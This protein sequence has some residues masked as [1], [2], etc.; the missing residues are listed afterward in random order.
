MTR[1][2]NAQ[3][4]KPALHP[5]IDEV[6]Y[7][8]TKTGKD[9]TR[10]TL[11][12][13]E[14]AK[15]NKVNRPRNL[16]TEFSEW[17]QRHGG[18][19]SRLLDLQHE[20]SSLEEALV[21]DMANEAASSDLTNKN[22][23]FQKLSKK[24]VPYAKQVEKHS[25]EWKQAQWEYEDFLYFQNVVSRFNRGESGFN[26]EE[27][28]T[29]D[30]AEWTRARLHQ[31]K[32][33][34]EKDDGMPTVRRTAYG[35]ETVNSLGV[36]RLL[37]EFRKKGVGIQ[38]PQ[39]IRGE[40]S[41]SD[42]SALQVPHEQLHWWTPPWRHTPGGFGRPQLPPPVEPNMEYDINEIETK[43]KQVENG[44]DHESGRL[45]TLEE[46]RALPGLAGRKKVGP[47]GYHVSADERSDD[48][49]TS[50][51]CTGIVSCRNVYQPGTHTIST[52]WAEETYGRREFHVYNLFSP[53][54]PVESPPHSP[55]V[56][57]GQEELTA[58]YI[59]GSLA[60]LSPI[61]VLKAGTPW[62]DL[63]R[64]RRSEERRVGKE[65]PV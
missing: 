9:I 45:Q 59:G 16:A 1:R 43:R 47:Y 35:E 27:G 8:R 18:T 20:I 32:T 61:D 25:T 4:E 60:L 24:Y 13:N 48:W 21:Q 56:S 49:P 39:Q 2:T 62:R 6:S 42:G 12:D 65:C 37:S 30:P 7:K 57:S 3:E 28:E 51:D 38:E 50:Y 14:R 17:F 36:Y 33:R 11:L 44:T 54:S 15:W 63:Y 22:T 53:P 34:L 29:T 10:Q 41:G 46:E 5:H 64:Y 58:Q 26:R 31:E 55:T 52:Q 40:G 19:Q 23:E